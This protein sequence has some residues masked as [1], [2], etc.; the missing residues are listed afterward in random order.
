MPRRKRSQSRR[1]RNR[2]FGSA[3]V[4]PVGLRYSPNIRRN[5]LFPYT[6]SPTL[7]RRSLLPMA[8]QARNYRT[9]YQG[10]VRPPSGVIGAPLGTG[11]PAHRVKNSNA[12]IFGKIGNKP[13]NSLR[14]AAR[15]SKAARNAL[16]RRR[17]IRSGPRM[18][19]ASR[20][21]KRRLR[22]RSS[23]KKRRPKRKSVKRKS[24]RKSVRRKM[25]SRRTSRTRRRR[26]SRKKSKKTKKPKR[27]R[28]VKK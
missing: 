16:G 26:V 1:R 23:S 25:K 7:V 28:S 27:R 5:V 12:M 11:Q 19:F 2:R 22:A 9:G 6:I 4:G 13:K 18:D 15:G 14:A 20:A 10:F 21:V 3:P 17:T 8:G 24:K